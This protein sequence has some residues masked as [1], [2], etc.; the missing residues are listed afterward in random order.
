M[1]ATDAW[2]TADRSGFLATDCERIVEELSGAA[3]RRGWHIEQEQHQE[4]SAS[5]DTLQG[6]SPESRRDRVE[7]IRLALNAPEVADFTEVILEYDFRRRGLRIDSILLAPGLIVV[8]E[9]KRTKLTA[10]D[11]DQVSHYCVNLVEFHEETRRLCEDHDV[12]VVPLLVLTKGEM[13]ARAFSKTT[14][15]QPPLDSV[16]RSPIECDRIG[17]RAALNAA[18]ELR[19]SREPVPA[20]P[21]LASRFSPSSTILDAAISLFGHHDVSAI[22]S[23]AAP[24]RAIAECTE[25]VKRHIED[26]RLVRRNRIIVV[27]GAPGSGKTLVGLRLAFDPDLRSDAVFVTGNAPLV[28]VLTK[29]LRNSYAG[30]TRR[31]GQLVASGYAREDIHH[32]IRNATFKIVKAHNF[33]GERGKKTD[34]TDG[35]TV[36]FD[37]AQRTYEKGRMVAGSKLADHEADLIL[38]SLER[39]Y[40]PGAVVVALLGENQAINRG[41]RGAIAWFEAAA[42]RGWDIAVGDETLATNENELSACREWTQSDRRKTLATGHLSH[43]MRFYR[44]KG[45]EMWAHAVLEEDC[46]EATC[47]AMELA[48]EG[49]A[50]T[51]TRELSEARQWAKARRVG[52]ERAGLIASGQARR[53]AAEGLFVELKPPIAHWML[54]PTGDIRSSNMLEVVQNQYQVQGLE[55]DYTIVCWD[56]DLRRGRKGWTAHKISGG[57]WQKDKAIEIAKNCYRVLL[58]RAR[59]GMTIFVP[60]GDASG[61]DVTRSADFYDGIAE[62][63]TRCGA[64]HLNLG[65]SQEHAV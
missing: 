36:I 61:E 22:D 6:Q 25:E 8:L 37:E 63:L 51:L 54:A 21:W 39:S 40:E 15:H 56:A 41:E 46:G 30:L 14:F 2:Y 12:I 57:G 9:F 24:A 1:T 26:A 33:L 35:N 43:S 13:P 49:H 38:E 60:R 59:K 62:Y 48:A 53:L 64:R 19:R 23:H 50:V 10:A 20:R 58:T 17:L 45:L 27:S 31:T 55:L 5:V 52:E 4:W 16:L 28:D 47:L 65:R 18:L 44:N 29:A 3:A 32:V 34:A 7:I 11:R 42:R